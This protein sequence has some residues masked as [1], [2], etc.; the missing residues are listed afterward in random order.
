[1]HGSDQG[2]R[3]SRNRGSITLDKTL[4]RYSEDDLG[5]NLQP[6]T[7]QSNA[8][9]YVTAIV[10]GVESSPSFICPSGRH[11]W[12]IR[13][14]GASGASI[15]VACGDALDDLGTWVR[16]VI[17]YKLST[18]GDGYVQAWKNGVEVAWIPSTNLGHSGS[19]YHYWRHGIYANVQTEDISL[20]PLVPA[21]W[22]AREIVYYDALRMCSRSGGDD[23]RTDT[24]D[25][26][27]AA[28]DPAQYPT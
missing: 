9:I 14:Y 1:V 10:G 16:F 19:A 28:V 22:A 11:Y 27:Y 26:A 12:G 20:D 21:D 13:G 23:A 7:N 4:R 25:P 5:T 6:T 8:Y 2:A 24:G 17:R 3:K 15:A 18:A